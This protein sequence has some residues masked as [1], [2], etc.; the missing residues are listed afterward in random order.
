MKVAEPTEYDSN[1]DKT[2]CKIILPLWTVSVLEYLHRI[3][4]M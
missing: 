3:E 4:D 2:S 1:V